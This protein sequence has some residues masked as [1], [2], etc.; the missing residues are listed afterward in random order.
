MAES[1]RVSGVLAAAITTS[2]RVAKFG[3][4]TCGRQGAS[5]AST[6]LMVRAFRATFDTNTSLALALA[7]PAWSGT[8]GKAGT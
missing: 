4:P 7:G 6:A 1:K 3:E 2:G 5:A 8:W